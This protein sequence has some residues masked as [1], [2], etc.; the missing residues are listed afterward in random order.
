MEQELKIRNQ[1]KPI[2]NEHSRGELFAAML[3]GARAAAARL[4]R[5]KGA[6]DEDKTAT[7]S[8]MRVDD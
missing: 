8:G 2:R 5:R 6:E 7:K 4:A 1:L 3:R